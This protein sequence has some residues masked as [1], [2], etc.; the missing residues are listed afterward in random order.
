V[1]IQQKVLHSLNTNQISKNDLILLGVSGG[2]DS[3]VMA[4]V[5]HALNWNIALAYFDHQLRS[6]ST[7]EKAF[8]QQLSENHGVPFYSGKADIAGTAQHER[9]SI[10][11]AAREKRYLFL[12]STAQE[13]NAKA[14]AVAH[15]ADDQVETI[16]MHILRG[17]GTRGLV[18]MQTYSVTAF[19]PNIPLVRPLLDV[20]REEIEEYCQQFSLSPKQDASNQD[21]TY[22]RN[23]IRHELI[24]EL[25]SYNAGFKTNLLHMS[26]I[27]KEDWGFLD[28]RYGAIFNE[29][30]DHTQNNQLQF[31]SVTFN[32]IPIGAQKAVLYHCLTKLNKTDEQ[33]DHQTVL[34][35]MEFINL[36]ERKKHLSLPAQLHA[37]RK[38][39]YIILTHSS[40]LPLEK[41]YPQCDG[42]YSFDRGKP[43][44]IKIGNEI[45]LEGTMRPKE[46]YRKPI[47]SDGFYWEAFMDAKRIKNQTLLVRRILAGERYTPLG[48]KGKQIKVSD[49]FINKKVPAQVRKSWPAI[50]DGSLIAWIPGF[51]PSHIY[52]IGEDTEEIYYLKLYIA[53]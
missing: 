18:G 19:H 47:P 1:D 49:L 10:E 51:A 38:D 21:K 43:F 9:K 22:L 48:M 32:Q 27:I 23:R 20:W 34:R 7:M 42:E 30:V 17:S 12:F 44:R 37:F 33:M 4:H 15:T 39:E 8:V 5:L 11:E 24:P 3:L 16:L 28:Q 6:Q 13:I 52:R 14:V 50:V 41:S 45:E 25:Q 2:P 31:S 35:L 53:K 40:F 36:Q 26:D 29:I 46:A